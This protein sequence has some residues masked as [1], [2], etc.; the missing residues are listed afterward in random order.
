[1]GVDTLTLV[2]CQRC[3]EFLNDREDWKKNHDGKCT[4][5]YPHHHAAQSDVPTTDA[6]HNHRIQIAVES[7]GSLIAAAVNDGLTADV[8]VVE[9]QIIGAD[10]SNYCMTEFPTVKI[11][12]F[13]KIL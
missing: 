7:L 11:G 4:I 5:L 6:E 3:W 12:L 2:Q 1:M 13:R 10:D 8:E 9:D